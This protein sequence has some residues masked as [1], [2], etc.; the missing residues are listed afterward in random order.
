MSQAVDAAPPA[1]S[2]RWQSVRLM[3]LA[4]V[5]LLVILLIRLDFD[6]IRAEMRNAD[7][8]LVLLATLC[9][10]PLIAIKTIRWQGILRVQD[11]HL[12]F[13]PA[14]LAYFASLFIGF[15]TP[16]RLGE[17]IKAVYVN[18]ECSVPPAQAFASVL[19]D[20]LFDLY[21]LLIVGSAALLSATV[22]SHS[23]LV[24]IMLGLVLTVPLVLFLHPVPFAWLTRIGLRCGTIGRKLFA[25]AGIL[26]NIRAGLSQLTWQWALVAAIL[27]GGAYLVFFGQCYVLAQALDL[28]VNFITVAY[29]VALGSLITLLPVSISG[30]G[31]REAVM[32]AFLD[33]SGI[34][35]EAALSFSL[36]IFVSFYIGGGLIGSL[37][38]WIKPV[39]LK[40]ITGTRTGGKSYTSE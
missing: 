23:L 2:S 4:G 25:E 5:I 13:R 20:R 12:A 28:R 26:P 35:A 24:V 6:H 39:P 15:L 19:A 37:A 32:I 17:F 14:L 29:T 7:W 9:I 16:G 1:R 21:A 27:T 30:L 22:V 10:V 40:D 36:L 3:R 8:R 38:W 11:V 18:R 31:T 33:S 34:A